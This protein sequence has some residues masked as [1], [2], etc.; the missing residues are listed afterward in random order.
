MIYPGDGPY[1]LTE[2][3]SALPGASIP[4][5]A[6]ARLFPPENAF[7]SDVLS[8]KHRVES[9]K[10]QID[11]C[12]RDSPD[13]TLKQRSVEGDDLRHVGDRVFRQAGHPRRQQGI[14]WGIRPPEIACERYANCRRHAASIQGIA[15]DDDDRPPEPGL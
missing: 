7:A 12:A 15:L 3:I 5:L 9:G 8:P 14:A 11:L 10:Q 6:T 4:A 2:Q 13:A 1:A